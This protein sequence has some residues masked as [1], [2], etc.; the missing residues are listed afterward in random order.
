M[1]EE[2]SIPRTT[3]HARVS[4][5][6]FTAAYSHFRP[7]GAAEKELIQHLSLPAAEFAARGHRAGIPGIAWNADRPR[8][9]F[10]IR[11]EARRE[12]KKI[13]PS[14]AIGKVTC[15]EAPRTSHIA[16]LVER[17][18]RFTMLI[19][20]ASKD[21]A[22]RRRRSEPTHWEAACGTFAP[23]VDLGSRTGKWPSTKVLRWTRR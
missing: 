11:E 14:R 12:S 13:A 22:S 1:A 17:H 5:K 7:G 9:P 4:T 20:V 23:L 16:T 18:S 6:R 2:V 21:T 19:K 10:S 3:G 15:W 8:A